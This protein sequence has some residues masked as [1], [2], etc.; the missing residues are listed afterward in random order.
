MNLFDHPVLMYIRCWAELRLAAIAHDEPPATTEKVI[1]TAI[2]AA[3]A[4]AAGAIIVLKITN[5][6]NSIETDAG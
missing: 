1:I 2:F 6:A 5:K 4:L 3:L